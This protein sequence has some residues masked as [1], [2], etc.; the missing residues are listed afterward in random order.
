M[1]TGFI[2]GKYLFLSV[3]VMG[4]IALIILTINSIIK[5][6]ANF[7]IYLPVLIIITASIMVAYKTPS[8][9]FWHYDE[10]KNGVG[11][12]KD[13]FKDKV[14]DLKDAPFVVGFKKGVVTSYNNVQD[15]VRN[16]Y[17]A[18]TDIPEK[19]NEIMDKHRDWC[20][21]IE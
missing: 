21:Y 3:I 10:V 17:A 19:Y 7:Y 13:R 12:V 8:G 15:G 20:M 14:N 4:L 18:I 16:T 1:S 2:A 9:T 5:N 6:D 11:N